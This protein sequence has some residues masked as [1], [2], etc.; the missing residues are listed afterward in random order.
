MII[1]SLKNNLTVFPFV[2]S[3]MSDDYMTAVCILIISGITDLFDGIIARKFNQ[4]TQLG[5]MIDP[6]ADKITL[7]AV[8]V[9]VGLKF[10]AVFPFMIIL[11]IKEVVMLLAGG[12]LLLMKRTPPA[13]KWYGKCATIAFYVSIILIIGAKAIFNY[14]SYDL[15]QILMYI[16]VACMLYSVVR[17]GQIFV[18][19][20]KE[21]KVENNTT[22]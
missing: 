18:K 6:T 17:Y 16:T 15:N 1:E 3:V 2:M 13:A 8:M 9:C 21:R 10:K 14:E 7:M 12:I 19:T 11:I 22:K 4:V 5:K 20:I